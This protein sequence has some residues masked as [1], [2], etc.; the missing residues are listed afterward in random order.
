MPAVADALVDAIAAEAA[1]WSP[2]DPFA[3][4]TLMGPLATPRAR[5]QFVAA[6]SQTLGLRTVVA[7]GAVEAEG[8]GCWVRAAVHEVVDADEAGARIAHELF[9][10]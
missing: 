1:R 9:G 10:P 4:S 3:A 5:D 8:S 7:G 2:G 6:Q